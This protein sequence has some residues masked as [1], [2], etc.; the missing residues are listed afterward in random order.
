M[1]TVGESVCVSVSFFKLLSRVTVQS[2]FSVFCVMSSSSSSVVTDDQPAPCGVCRFS[3]KPG[4]T[5]VKCNKHYHVT[6]FSTDY[7]PFCSARCNTESLEVPSVSGLTWK[8]QLEHIEK[9]I[10]RTEKLHH[11]HNSIQ[12]RQKFIAIANIEIQNLQKEYERVSSGAPPSPVVVVSDDE[13]KDDDRDRDYHGIETPWSVEELKQFRVWLKD[14]RY[15]SW[16]AFV[17]EYNE[18]T[19]YGLRTEESLR[20]KFRELGLILRYHKD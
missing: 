4:K 11:I 6:Y 3:G 18:A 10:Y 14:Y 12:Q 8:S 1:V 7:S 9:N 2:I 19:E 16:S 5:C 20:K 17:D 13:E 15:H